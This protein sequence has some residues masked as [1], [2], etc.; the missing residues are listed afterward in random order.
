MSFL[1]AV[2]PII[3]L[4]G[5]GLT[6]FRKTPGVKIPPLPAPKE[7]LKGPVSPS[8]TAAAAK[9]RIA[10]RARQGKGVGGLVLNRGVSQPAA[11]TRATLLGG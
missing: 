10:G 7:P 6:L 9:A 2:A 1:S 5:A 4:A 3:G 11:P 8:S